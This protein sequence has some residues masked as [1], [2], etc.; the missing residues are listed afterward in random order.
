M[1]LYTFF[2]CAP[3]GTAPHFEVRELAD[4]VAA[5]GAAEGLLQ[6]HASSAFIR[7][8]D[9]DRELP[10]VR[11]QGAKGDLTAALDTATAG[12]GEIAV[13]ATTAEGAVTY[14]NDAAGKLYGWATHEALGRNILDLTP[15]LQSRP[16]AQSI[17][18]RLQNGET[19]AGEIVLKGRDGVPFSAFVADIPLLDGAGGVEAIVGLS[20]RAQSAAGLQA[21]RADLEAAILRY[22]RAPR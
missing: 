15:S 3:S 11:R 9:E 5:T 10:Q 20:A 6:S 22:A 16:Q 1:P 14:W 19:W 17:M 2:C 4:D 21:E 7:I 12:R 8:F 18:R 13:I